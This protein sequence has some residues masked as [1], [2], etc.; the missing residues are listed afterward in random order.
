M[1]RIG[2]LG[3]TFNPLHSGHIALA[4]EFVG[5]AGLSKILL[6]PTAMP[7][8]KEAADLA[9]EADRLNM[10]RLVS[11]EDGL[12]EASDIE[13]RRGGKSYTADTLDE[14]KNIYPDTEFC[15]IVGADMF[16]TLGSWHR[17]RDILNSAI[18]C[19]AARDEFSLRQMRNYAQKIGLAEERYILSSMP[20]LDISSTDIRQR[21]KDGK[22]I[23]GLVPKTVEDYIY[24]NKLYQDI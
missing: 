11:Q 20:R 21:V 3:G 14:L 5:M 24:E 8:H 2:I 13:Q 7:P 22:S 6:I 16:V 17:S 15:L 4:R 9:G 19:S 10:C 12:F 23:K 18:I 1:R